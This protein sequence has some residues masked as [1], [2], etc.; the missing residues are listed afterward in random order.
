MVLRK[1]N[2]R[3]IQK[4]NGLSQAAFDKFTP[5]SL[6]SRITGDTF[7][8][9]TGLNS[10]FAYFYAHPLLFLALYLWPCKLT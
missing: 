10:S 3:F 8:I 7:Q 5:S 2:R 1:F 9:Q 6:I 4:N